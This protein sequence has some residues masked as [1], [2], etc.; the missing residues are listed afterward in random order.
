MCCRKETEPSNCYYANN[1]YLRTLEKQI[2]TLFFCI[3]FFFRVRPIKTSCIKNCFF[4]HVELDGETP[5]TVELSKK[6]MNV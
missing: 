1:C 2:H 6:L 4:S 5:S 3:F